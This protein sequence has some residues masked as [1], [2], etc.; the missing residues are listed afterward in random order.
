[1]PTNRPAIPEAVKADV[2]RR[3]YFGCIVCGLPVW[4]YDHV[5]PWAT[6]QEH[7]VENI[8][9][10]CRHHHGEKTSR[11]LS[12]ATVRHYQQRPFNSGR[13]RSATYQ[14]PMVGSAARLVIGSNVCSFDFARSNGRFDA[15]RVGSTPILGVT[16]EDGYLLLDVVMM[17]QQGREILR[18][19][20]G[21]LTIDPGVWDYRFS[22]PNFQIRGGPGAVV[23]DLQIVDNG[24]AI[25]Q[26]YFVHPP[27]AVHI[28]PDVVVI[29]PGEQQFS[30]IETAGIRVA[31]QIGQ[32][33]QNSGQIGLHIQ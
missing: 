5:V 1:M 16:R 31:F 6:V 2:R 32:P 12:D 33:P 4:D 20:R 21:E 9:L 25:R 11:R 18:I 19:D 13:E 29:Y 3:C 15:I 28:R 7:T 14:L 24:I 10:L 8:V 17:D 26:G 23:L 22:G 27:R 30:R